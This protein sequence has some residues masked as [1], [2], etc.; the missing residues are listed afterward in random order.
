MAKHSQ[1]RYIN[2]P[3]EKQLGFS[4]IVQTGNTLRLSGIVSVDEQM[5]V[6]APEDMVAQ[7]EQIYNIMEQT[8][9]KCQATLADVVNEMIFVTDMAALADSAAT[10]ARLARYGDNA[11]PSAT[12]VQ[13]SALFSPGAVIEIQATAV[14]D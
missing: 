11:P 9:A 13:V 14:L 7:I 4:A 3:V 5:N 8:L 12:A 2:E 6:V 10:A 1:V